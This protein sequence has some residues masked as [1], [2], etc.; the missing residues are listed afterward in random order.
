MDRKLYQI[1]I[2]SLKKVYDGNCKSNKS[3]QWNSFIYK[4]KNQ[5]IQVLAIAGTNGTADWFWNLLLLQK[6]GVKMGSYV[7]AQRILKEFIRSPDMPLL[8]AV[9]SKSGPT[10]IYL[11]ELLNAEYCVSFCP[12]RGFIED[13]EN[14]NT[15]MF[16]DRDDIVPKVGWSRFKHRRCKTIYLPK[17]KEWYNIG[18]K[19][20][21]HFL[22]HIEEFIKN[23]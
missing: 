15:I 17:D 20:K 12:A 4:I 22:K 5:K 10:G 6:D 11:Q 3:T 8:I 19:L 9:H 2:D 21:D 1:A 13:K 14:K 23:M 7:S 18:G 16:I